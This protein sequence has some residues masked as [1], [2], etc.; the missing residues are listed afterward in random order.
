MRAYGSL[1]SLGSILLAL[2]MGCQHCVS[3]DNVHP[4]EVSEYNGALYAA[5]VLQPN[6]EDVPK[7]NGMILFKHDSPQSNLS[8][9]FQLRGFDKEAAEPK[10][11]HIHQ[12]GDLSMGCT[13]TGGHYNPHNV[14]HPNHPGDFG[15][16]VTQDGRITETIESEATLFGGHSVIGRAVVIHEK[17]DDLGQGGDAASLQN[18]NAGARI[19]CCVIGISSPDLWNKPP[20]NSTEF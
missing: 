18:G 9:S 15:N 20:Q 2:L 10:A 12:F 14:D 5:C 1:C 3:C 7:V 19:G 17:Q 13:S 11:V 16:F 8:V 4:P 6:T